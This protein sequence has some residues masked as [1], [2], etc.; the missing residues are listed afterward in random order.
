M[1]SCGEWPPVNSQQRMGAE[2]GVQC[3]RC[4]ELNSANHCVSW[5]ESPELLKNE[6]HFGGAQT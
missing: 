5:K 6:A 3:D 2:E 1:T 4:K